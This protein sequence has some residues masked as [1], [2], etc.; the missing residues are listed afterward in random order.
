MIHQIITGPVNAQQAKGVELHGDVMTHWITCTGN[1]C[2]QLAESWKDAQGRV[3]PGLLR[4]L[5]VTATP[6]QDKV[7]VG[8]FSAGGQ[9]WKQAMSN[10]DDR[11][12]I[13]GA[14]MS[15]AGYE[16][17][18]VD[19]KADVAPPAEGYV[20][21]ALDALKDGRLFVWTASG[22]PNIP[23]AD[24]VYP[25]GNLVQ[26]ATR[27]AI[28]QR[29]GE[30]F[31][32]VTERPDLWPWGAVLRAPVRV[33]RLRNVIFADYGT[34]YKHAEHATVIA[35]EVWR[36]IPDLLASGAAPGI[37][38][39]WWSRRSP[40]AKAGIIFAGS[41]GAIFGGRALFAKKR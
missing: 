25:A 33:W 17:A 3:L 26:E 6:E 19:Q 12:Q 15:D 2:R 36:A 4:Y 13:E 32:D 10:A 40:W 1:E 5:K 20:L 29:S 9:I 7:L 41:F 35:P 22:F 27:L 28:E 30:R 21:Y 34:V 31:E 11:A 24:A 8:A 23:H 39:S 16:A 38:G 14:V 18:W 37:A